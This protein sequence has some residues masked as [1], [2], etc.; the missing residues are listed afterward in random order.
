MAYDSKH[1]NTMYYKRPATDKELKR[2]SDH[3]SMDSADPSCTDG[4]GPEQGVNQ[5]PEGQLN[6]DPAGPKRLSKLRKK[7]AP[8]YDS[9]SEE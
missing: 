9:G 6:R 3:S 2:S 4:Y 8:K 7:G 1:K 5:G